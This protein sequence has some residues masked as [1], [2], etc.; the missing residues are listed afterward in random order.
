MLST[1]NDF[2]F[3][4]LNRKFL[5]YNLVSRNLKIRY[6]KSFLGMLWTVLMPAGSAVVYYFVFSIILKVNVEH[7]LLFIIS[8]LIPWTFFSNSILV[9]IESIVVSAAL[10]KK[11]PMP[12]NSPSLSDVLTGF[13]NLLLSIPVILIVM[14][15]SGAQPSW[16]LVQY[17]ILMVLLFFITYSLSILLG[18]TYVY[19]RDVRY[20]MTLLLQ[21]WFYLT[22]IMY[23]AEMIPEKYRWGLYLNPVGLVFVGMSQSVTEGLWLNLNEWTI[24]FSWTILIVLLSK[25][26]FNKFSS[27][28]VELL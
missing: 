13:L 5:I 23:T 11:V 25:L 3:F 4:C 28:I 12:P 8:G 9:G 17:P 26:I 20:F 10:L 2:Q 18:F 7:H 6:R 24:I 21:L 15:L 14:A 19:F 27:K 22:P 1:K 16:A